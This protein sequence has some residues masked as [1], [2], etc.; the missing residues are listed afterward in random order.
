MT[1]KKPPRLRPGAT[2]GLI[3]P[4]GAFDPRR[5]RDGV[6]FLE[7]QGFHVRYRE[8]I[9]QRYRYLAGSD[10]RRAAELMEYLRDPTID[11]IFCVRGGYGSQRL[12]PLLD[13]TQLPST[14]KILV[15]YSD[16]TV[17]QGFLYRHAQW[18]GFYGPTVAKHLTAEAPRENFDWLMKACGQTAPLG[19]LPS[20]TLHVIKPGTAEGPLVGG[21]L[22]LLQTG[23]GTNYAWPLRGG[24]CFLEDVDEKIYALDRLLTHLKHAGAFDG[25]RGICFGTLGLSPHETA[26]DNL[27]PMLADIFADFPGPVV[28]GFS[29]GHADPFCT[30]P[31]GCQA[32]LSTEPPRLTITESAVI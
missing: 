31:L 6:A 16:I 20:G 26:P 7:S 18:G 4:A 2:I 13:P 15:G 3:A 21:C 27:D 8:D 14:P 25:V 28:R 22:S 23:I 19:A 32:I 17:L 24:I 9:F 29:A 11:A 30:L 1:L 10:A 12:I 5:F